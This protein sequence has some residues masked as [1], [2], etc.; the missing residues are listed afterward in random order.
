MLASV[1][2]AYVPAADGPMIELQEPAD[3]RDGAKVVATLPAGTRL[4]VFREEGDWILVKAADLGQ[5]AWLKSAVPHRIVGDSDE[6]QRRLRK[7]YR[8]Y[9]AYES[10]IEKDAPG[11]ALEELR[12]CL[13]IERKVL[14][15]HP[16]VG[17]SLHIL[18]L[19]LS[20]LDRDAEA[21]PLYV[22]AL[23]IRERFLGI[24]HEDTADTLNNLGV[25]YRALAR[26][27]L[28]REQFNRALKIYKQLASDA[29]AAMVLENLGNLSRLR[30]HFRESREYLDRALAINTALQG[31][32]SPE[33]ADILVELGN[34]MFDMDDND[35]ARR[36]Y[37]RALEIYL[38]AYGEQHSDTAY[39]LNSL[40]NLL[41]FGFDDHD[42]AKENYERALAIYSNLY[43]RQHSEAARTL[44]NLGALAFKL[45][46]YEAARDYFLQAL[47][48][49]RALFGEEH[50]DIATTLNQL[51]LLAYELGDW[52]ETREYLD[53]ALAICSKLVGEQ[54]I[55]TADTLLNLGNL[56][57]DLGDYEAAEDHYQRALAVYR[58]LAGANSTYTAGPLNSLGA[59]AMQRGEFDKAREFFTQAL[60]VYRE[61]LGER[62]VNT[63]LMLNNL[64]YFCFLMGE[65]ESAQSYL[66][67]AL[68][69]WR[70]RYG[71]EHVDTAMA[72][73][74]LGI[75]LRDTG[76]F[77]AAREHIESALATRRRL[78]GTDH[79]NNAMTLIELA[80]LAI[81]S[82][83]QTAAIEPLQEARR[84][85]R[86]HLATVLPTLSSGEQI[87]YLAQSETENFAK[88]LSYA[89]QHKDS[90]RVRIQSVGWLINGK[91][92]G[93]EALAEG[94]LLA[95]PETIEDVRRLRVVRSRLSQL[96]GA[97]AGN[98]NEQKRREAIAVLEN[99]QQ[100]LH[101]KIASAGTG[102]SQVDPW[103]T[104]GQLR[105]HLDS[106]SVMIQIARF[107]P[108][109]FHSA[110]TPPGK[111]EQRWGSAN[112]VAWVIPASG[113]G[114]VKI[115]ELGLSNE[116]DALVS[117][118]VEA[119]AV[120]ALHFGD[121]Q[122]RA[123]TKELRP[124]LKQLAGRI[125][126][127]LLPF[128]GDAEE[129]VLSPDGSL[130]LVPWAALLVDE[131]YLIEKYD[132]RYVVSGR[133]VVAAVDTVTGVSAPVIAANPDYDLDLFALAEQSE[134]ESEPASGSPLG[135][136]DTRALDN[137]P[138]VSRLPGTA[139]E[140]QLIAPALERYS[141]RAPQLFVEQAA[142]EAQIKAVFRPR[143]LVLSTHGFFFEDQTAAVR[144][145]TQSVSAD[146]QPL[147]LAEDG[148]VLG[149][150]LL[151]CGLLFAG[152]NHREKSAVAGTEDGVLTGL[153]VVGIDL[154]GTELVVLSA[155]DTGRG[156]VRCGE[157][158]AGL[159]QAFQFA[160][161]DA[162]AASLWRIPDAATVPL[163]Q[164]FFQ[165]LA[166]GQTKSKALCQ[167]QR[168]MIDYRR[169][170]AG[171]AHPFFW[172]AFT[173]TGK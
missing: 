41:C 110:A 158:V 107:R 157:G 152:C 118:A 159:R 3:L 27:E 75:L 70:A 98:L 86:R 48:I 8:H 136:S 33:C 81:M 119:I 4:F 141:R 91:A 51:G 173:L 171:V 83:E 45:D 63:A 59:L 23:K 9:A 131:D 130:W 135:L 39:T 35:S 122:E 93:Q 53:A 85:A 66:E 96:G 13:A 26:Y 44:G 117:S 132:L 7:A 100:Q 32:S 129:L 80:E 89:Q 84:L 170:Q 137:L 30:G 77:E 166:D 150:P 142:S 140:A 134:N 149:N 143:V 62:N 36:H 88:C 87:R 161:A 126:A 42:G 127:P 146:R 18:G 79:P 58:S 6:E 164:G 49:Y 92:I 108:Y 133:E 16:D 46:D 139:R 29:D 74:N 94:S 116:I 153:E 15:E 128:V 24:D 50:M 28:A 101:R 90:S 25:V 121:A 162:V 99:E 10:Q 145:A 5:K 60:S 69:V 22:E 120:D 31:E 54:H 61:Q 17:D 151:R 104:P 43:G 109:D 112:Y 21:E 19:A 123:A 72:L 11:P 97:L 102:M 124:L 115:V 71:Q 76:H 64:G 125:L 57:L 52:V 156:D 114:D 95:R 73:E 34:L 163:M 47:N 169:T 167:A 138:R 154:R 37:S 147:A 55:S 20:E 160:G 165:N 172:A 155:C 103:I 144:D 113:E 56:E 111:Q 82:G 14:G 2:A 106:R 68:D 40:G 65:Y 12:R 67:N 1:I 168:A 38:Q 105:D 148:R 78:L